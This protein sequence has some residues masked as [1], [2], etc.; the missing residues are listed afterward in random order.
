MSLPVWPVAVEHR[1]LRSAFRVI[2]PHVKPLETEL[3]GGSIRRRPS[4]TIR[5]ALLAF[6]WDWTDEQYTIFRTFYHLTLSEGALR[7]TMS[8][9][10]GDLYVERSCQ[11]K[12]MYEATRP[13]RF[14]RIS[15]QIHIFG[16]P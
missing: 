2:E 1:P 4:T 8:V 15:A 7:F 16:G 14:W 12:G 10:D 3:E 5:R 11:F 13:T 9:P 6:G